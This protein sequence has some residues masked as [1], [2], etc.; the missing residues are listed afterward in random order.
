MQARNL[1]LKPAALPMDAGRKRLW[2]LLRHLFPSHARAI[3]T[4]NGALAISWSLE[5]DPNSKQRAAAPIMIVATNELFE[6]LLQGASADRT[7]VEENCLEQVKR[8]LLRYDP[9]A[10]FAQRRVI[11]I[12]L[13]LV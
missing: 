4:E 8:G 11:N 12:D 5:H 3:Q 7:A 1:H 6:V 9:Y 13:P 10:E 2:E